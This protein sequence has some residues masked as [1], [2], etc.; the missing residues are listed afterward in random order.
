MSPIVFT[1]YNS[2]IIIRAT[3]SQVRLQVD[4]I[5]KAVLLVEKTLRIKLIRV[6][7]LS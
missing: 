7:I 1:I 4:Y 5:S 6:F 3:H 2:D